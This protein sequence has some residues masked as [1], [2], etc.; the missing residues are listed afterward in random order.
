MF[1]W[2]YNYSVGRG[3]TV[4][5]L[6]TYLFHT[7]PAP[8]PL[9]GNIPHIAKKDKIV[10]KGLH[11]LACEYGP[12]FTLWMGP[13]KFVVV[14]GVNELKVRPFFKILKVAFSQKIQG[15]NHYGGN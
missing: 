3:N 1:V 12:M 6:L 8:Y 11:K 10:F 9:V 15:H 2:E 13:R 14:S 7:G 4:P 5:L